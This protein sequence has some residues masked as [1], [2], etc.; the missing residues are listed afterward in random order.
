[1]NARKNWFTR[2]FYQDS[3]RAG[4]Q[5]DPGVVAYCWTGARPAAI[6]IRDISTTGL[7]LLTEER[8]YV[9]TVIRL[10]VQRTDC[11][12]ESPERSIVIRSRVVRS[13]EKGVGLEFIL[14][15][16]QDSLREKIPA[17]QTA[18]RRTLHRFLELV[19]SKGSEV[20]VN[21]E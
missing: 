5:L 16:P 7:Y 12:A 9:G 19:R 15:P 6:S 8:W 14:E 3:R 11:S 20:T 18:D 21:V 10:T 2:W 13:D 17:E 1:M 4:R